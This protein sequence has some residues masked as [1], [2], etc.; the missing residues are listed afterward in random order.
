[1]F[2]EQPLPSGHPY[3]GLDNVVIT[4]HMA[5]LTE[6]SMMRMGLGAAEEAL[7]VLRG[8]LPKNLRNPEALPAFHRRFTNSYP[9]AA[10]K[11]VAAS[12]VGPR[13]THRRH[14]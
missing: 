9:T 3:Y 11:L 13:L 5:G 7:R 12:V 10:Q 8:D 1:M 4:P 14:P 2:V 6:K